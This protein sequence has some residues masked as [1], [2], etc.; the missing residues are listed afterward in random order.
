MDAVD[1]GAVYVIM[2]KLSDL[3]VALVSLYEYFKLADPFVGHMSFTFSGCEQPQ[4]VADAVEKPCRLTS[5]HLRPV[6]EA[7]VTTC[8]VR[9]F[10]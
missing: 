9:N 7:F 3:L 6:L 1:C 5:G 4:E 2:Y 10:G 8:V